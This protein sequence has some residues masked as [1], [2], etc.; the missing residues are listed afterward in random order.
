MLR[1]RVR[2]LRIRSKTGCVRLYSAVQAYR[3]TQGHATRIAWNL[4]TLTREAGV[5]S[6][7]VS[8]ELG[9]A[10]YEVTRQHYT[11]PGVDE[12]ARAKGMLRVVDGGRK[13][14]EG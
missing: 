14:G 3:Y 7:A 11:A 9:H 13:D 6:H 4:A 10:D 5:S 2:R 12:R 1:T 8:K